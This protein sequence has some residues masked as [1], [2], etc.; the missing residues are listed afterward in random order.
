[1][2]SKSSKASCASKKWPALNS[3]TP[4]SNGGGIRGVT[5]ARSPRLSVHHHAA[6]RLAG[7]HEIE[8]AV[9]VGERHG[10]GH[11]LV[12]LDAALHVLVDHPW[13]LGAPARAAER[14]AAPGA[15]GDEEERACMDLLARTRDADD[16]RLAPA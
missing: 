14:G 5:G 6:D 7:V 16:D 9:D 10:G 1:S 2:S 15:P 11:H 12:E 4:S 8:G 3:A 13:Q